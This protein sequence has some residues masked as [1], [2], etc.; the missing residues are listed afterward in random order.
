MG[1][2]DLV[3]DRD[4]LVFLSST[5]STNTI[6]YRLAQEGLAD[7]TC[8]IADAQTAGKGRQNRQ[9]HSPPGLNL[10]LSQ[11]VRRKPSGL[12]L[13]GMLASVATRETLASFVPDHKA[14]S[15]KWPNDILVDRKK[16]A[17]ILIQLSLEPPESFGIAGIGIN[18]NMQPQQLPDKLRWPA[19]SIA[20][21]NGQKIERRSVLLKLLESLA[22]WR[23]AEQSV[24]R[25]TYS[26]RV[27]HVG[28]TRACPPS[29]G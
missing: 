2:D 4:D 3:L 16:V 27:F 11:I 21:V 12:S 22:S 8:V 5:S 7:G 29:I 25:E 14:A 23:Q 24:L 17:G 6:A 20:M 15:I 1:L 19:T 9:W 13:L 26:Q 10:Y 28:E 18:V